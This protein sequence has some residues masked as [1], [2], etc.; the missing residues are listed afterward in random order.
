MEIV[1]QRER[2]RVARIFRKLAEGFSIP[3][4]IPSEP[5]IVVATDGSRFREHCGVLLV[6]DT[7]AICGVRPSWRDEP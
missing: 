2:S 7:C 3:Q 6:G 4:E 5:R 1:E